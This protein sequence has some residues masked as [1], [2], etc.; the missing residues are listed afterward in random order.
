MPTTAAGYPPVVAPWAKRD[1]MVVHEVEPYNA[2]TPPGALAEGSLTAVDAF[3]SRNHGPIPDIDPDRWRLTVD[4]LVASPLHLSL[5]DLRERFERRV[6]TAT[7]QCAGNR[8]A[9]LIAVRDIP[10]EAPWGPGA[11]STAQWAGVALADVLHAAGLAPEAAH[12]GF[13]APDVTS[14]ANPRRGMAA[15]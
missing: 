5:S 12:V 10:G 9:G 13:S 14:L 11:T 2:E 1:D 8:R 3:F 7:L 4:G 6:V 15:P